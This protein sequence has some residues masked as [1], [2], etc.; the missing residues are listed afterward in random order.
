[1]GLANV[2]IMNVFTSPTHLYAGDV[3]PW[4]LESKLPVRVKASA[5]ALDGR[6]ELSCSGFEA[7]TATGTSSPKITI[8]WANLADKIGTVSS[9]RRGP[10]MDDIIEKSAMRKIY[11]RLLPYRPGPP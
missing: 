7:R 9:G 3:R 10:Q 2:P 1:M 8:G 6:T 11:L 5:Q 4:A